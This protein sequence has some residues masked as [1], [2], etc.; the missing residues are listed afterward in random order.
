MFR[1]TLAVG[2]E[3]YKATAR[4]TCAQITDASIYDLS[5]QQWR[6]RIERGPA[7]CDADTLSTAARR[8]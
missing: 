2:S 5:A 7:N 1:V 4:G 3:S 8:Q 6:G